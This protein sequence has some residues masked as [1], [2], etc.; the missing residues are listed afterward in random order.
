MSNVIIV[1][2]LDVAELA[3]YVFFLFFLGLVVYLRREDR[4]EGYPLQ[5]DL[6]GEPEWAD[7]GILLTAPAK[8][9][10]LP[11]DHGTVSMPNG[12][13]DPMPQNVSKRFH[14]GSPFEPLGNPLT[15]GVGPASWC[16]RA[17]RPDV[18]QFNRPRIV[19]AR[20]N[21]HL[22]VAPG[23]A[24]PRGLPIVGLDDVIAG[25]VKDLWVDRAENVLR[26]LEVELTAG[27]TVLVPMAMCEVSRRRVL[28]DAVTGAQIA[29]SPVIASPDQ[30]TLLEEDKVQA[31][32]G[33]GYL[34]ATAARSEPYL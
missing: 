20:L 30:I 12:A 25:T 8:T 21:D 9:F 4:R 7:A 10:K 14:S 22:F 18:D 2:G 15:S 24:D 17:D 3:F 31:Y 34:W 26:Y 19:P 28:V 6:T 23:D 16:A 33:A 29:G 1:G 32:F 13:A 27:G 5:N 11:F